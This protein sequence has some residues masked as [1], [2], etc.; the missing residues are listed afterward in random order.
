MTHVVTI[1]AAPPGYW[2]W[3][4]TCGQTA[5]VPGKVPTFDGGGS[6]AELFPGHT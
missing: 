1:H 4:C 5:T 3:D 2:R 6:M